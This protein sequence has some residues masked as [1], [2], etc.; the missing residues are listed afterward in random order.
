MPDRR[1][2]F[3]GIGLTEN[4]QRTVRSFVMRAG[5]MTEAQSRAISDLWPVFGVDYEKNP[6]EFAR[7]FGRPAPVVLEIGFGNG[8]SL[9]QQAADEQEVNFL[10]VE[11]HPPGV[12]HL[13][14]TIRQLELNNIRISR[15]D[16]VEVLR[17]Q[18]PNN[19]LAGVNMFFPDPWPKKR[20]H[21]RRIVQSNFVNMVAKKLQPEAFLHL[22]TDWQPYAE[23]MLATLDRCSELINESGPGC[24]SDRLDSRTL[25]KFEARGK[26]L[27][28]DV[29]DLRYRKS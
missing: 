29:W 14:I 19:S 25:T 22:A 11:V 4:R 3:L 1:H 9:A 6:L 16:A 18:V 21:K 17:D 8:E 26:R 20:H 5:R 27:G 7:L 2:H 15:H 12:G 28:H 24:F 10:G 23:H 13:L